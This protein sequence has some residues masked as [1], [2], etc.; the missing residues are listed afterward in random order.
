MSHNAKVLVSRRDTF[1]DA[2]QDAWQLSTTA[3]L[4]PS[5]RL[6]TG[7]LFDFCEMRIQFAHHYA[8]W[9]NNKSNM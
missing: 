7:I 1:L 5:N 9:L 6:T 8:V 4:L 3:R 2:I